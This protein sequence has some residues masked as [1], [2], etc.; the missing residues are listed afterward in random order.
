MLLMKMKRKVQKEINMNSMKIYL[1]MLAKQTTPRIK[2]QTKRMKHWN[3]DFPQDNE[4]DKKGENPSLD[5][6]VATFH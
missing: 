4:N 2:L 5:D 6:P 3:I 1:K